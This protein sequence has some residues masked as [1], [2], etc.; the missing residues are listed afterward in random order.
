MFVKRLER[1]TIYLMDKCKFLVF[2]DD[3]FSDLKK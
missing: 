2:F 1:F 3:V